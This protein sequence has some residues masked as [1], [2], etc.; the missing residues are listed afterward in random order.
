MSR[1]RSRMKPTAI[2]RILTHGGLD[3]KCLKVQESYDSEVV[4]PPKVN[5]LAKGLQHDNVER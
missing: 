2:H 1:M 4:S 3:W 5:V